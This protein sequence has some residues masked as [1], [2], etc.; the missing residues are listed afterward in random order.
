MNQH[1]LTNFNL[2]LILTCNINTWQL[3]VLL[4]ALGILIKMVC[5]ENLWKILKLYFS[6]LKRSLTFASSNPLN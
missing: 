5:L 4:T 6:E 2:D 1:K 3:D